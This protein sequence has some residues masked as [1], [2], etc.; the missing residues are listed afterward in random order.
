MSNYFTSFPSVQYDTTGKAPNQFQTVKNIMKRQK[1]KPSIM[2][3][4]TAYYPYFIQ[5]GERPDVVSYNY[6]GSTDY[7]YLIFL[8]N[9][10]I[11]PAFDWPLSSR[12]FDNY[13]INK[14]GNIEAALGETKYYYQI[15]RAEVPQTN[16]SDRIDEVKIIVDETTYNS[17]SIGSRKLITSYDYEVEL[18]EIKRSIKL[19]NRDLISDVDYQFKR[20]MR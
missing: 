2:E 4:I 8:I 19:I 1:L 5:E 9:N 10:I 11:D 20:E 13:M 3:D 12:D 14:Y 17:L 7:V 16:F 15:I 18:N 6:Y